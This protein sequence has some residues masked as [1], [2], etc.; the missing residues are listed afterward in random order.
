[1]PTVAYT[2]IEYLIGSLFQYFFLY[3]GT[4][5]QVPYRSGLFVKA[6]HETA[7]PRSDHVIGPAEFTCAICR[8]GA[9]EETL[10][11]LIAP[12]REA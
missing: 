7:C 2:Y 6:A 5:A 11:A 10:R 4:A 12:R 1:M 8:K 9:A 3:L